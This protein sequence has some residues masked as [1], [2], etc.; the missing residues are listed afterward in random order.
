MMAYLQDPT[1]LFYGAATFL[2]VTRGA[3]S[4]RPALF[5]VSMILLA[6]WVLW[7]AALI[8]FGYAHAPVILP[9]LDAMMLGFAIWPAMQDANARV[10]AWLYLI[11]IGAW[12]IFIGTGNQ[13]TFA[14]YATANGIFLAQLLTVGLAGAW[15]ALRAG[16][17]GLHRGRDLRPSDGFHAGLVHELHR[18]PRKKRP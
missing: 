8:W 13:A 7:N 4:N 6:D 18:T 3:L 14:C 17:D 12:A 11:A 10:V 9:C 15:S 5:E 16:M 1:F 2:V